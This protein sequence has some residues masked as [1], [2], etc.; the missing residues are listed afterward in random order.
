[1]GFLFIR[2]GHAEFELWNLL[3]FQHN[4]ANAFMWL[5]PILWKYSCYFI[6]VISR[7]GID[8]VTSLWCICIC[9]LYSVAGLL[10]VATPAAKNYLLIFYCFCRTHIKSTSLLTHTNTPSYKTKEFPSKIFHYHTSIILLRTEK[11]RFCNS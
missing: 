3:Y 2:S 4:K 1:M 8:V 10:P 6:S 7:N 11:K 9:I 5:I